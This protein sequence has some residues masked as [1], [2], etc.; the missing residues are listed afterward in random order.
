[1]A[2]LL[3]LATLDKKGLV[4]AGERY[5]VCEGT[6]QSIDFNSYQGVSPAVVMGVNRPNPTGS[7][8]STWFL[9]IQWSGYSTI[10][11]I[12]VNFNDGNIYKRIHLENSGWSD[13]ES[14]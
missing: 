5:G 10:F 6:V 1:M 9:L 11:Q 14:F 13:W 8:N 3:P 4:N 7:G 12:A 2:G